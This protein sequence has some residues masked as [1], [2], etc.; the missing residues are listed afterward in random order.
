MPGGS[1]LYELV[2]QNIEIP[3]CVT[4]ITQQI[5][6]HNRYYT[7]VDQVVWLCIEM[8]IP[9]HKFGSLLHAGAEQVVGV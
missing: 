7:T 1:R 4:A 3:V 6:L 2:S 5:L 8:M 9:G